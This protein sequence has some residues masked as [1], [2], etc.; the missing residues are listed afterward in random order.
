MPKFRNEKGTATKKAFVKSGLKINSV[1]GK[2]PLEKAQLRV[3]FTMV[4]AQRVN[5]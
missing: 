5:K 4:K 3:R 1:S 2:F